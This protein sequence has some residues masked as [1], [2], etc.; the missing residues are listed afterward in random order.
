MAVL[1]LSRQL[2]ACVLYIHVEGAVAC[3]LSIAGHVGLRR[4]QSQAMSLGFRLQADC[5]D[6]LTAIVVLGLVSAVAFSAS[7]QLVSRFANKVCC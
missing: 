3:F 6:L 5:R 1:Q 7:Y 2:C 4:R